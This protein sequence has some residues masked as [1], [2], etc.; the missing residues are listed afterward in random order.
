MC[1]QDLNTEV[2]EI[3]RALCVEGFVHTE[4]T[5]APLAVEDMSIRP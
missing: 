3:L 4:Y 2:T 5:E 1:L